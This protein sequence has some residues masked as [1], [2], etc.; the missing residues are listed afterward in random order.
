[1]HMNKADPVRFNDVPSGTV[2]LH[3]RFEIFA[4]FSR[5]SKVR[6]KVAAEELVEKA[7]KSAGPIAR[8]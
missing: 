6:G 3:I 2:K 4:L 7:V 1:M 8:K 5:H